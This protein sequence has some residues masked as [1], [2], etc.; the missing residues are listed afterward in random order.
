MRKSLLGFIL[1]SLCILSAP[2]VYSQE[3]EPD[4]EETEKKMDK[5]VKQAYEA[6]EAEEY[7]FAIE[8]LKD[9]FTEVRGRDEKTEI[10]FMLGESYRKIND[11]RSAQSYY[12]KAVKLGY[13]DPVAQ[14]YYADMLKAQGE[15]EEAITAYQEYR[16]ANPS[17]S[18]G[19]M[20]I[21]S[22]KKAVEWIEE[23]SR[24]QVDNMKDFN[25]RDMDFSVVIAGKRG[26]NELI[27]VSSRDES[28]GNKEDGWTGQSF[29]DLY[30]TSAERKSR[31]RRGRS[32][33]G[34]EDLKPME[35]KWS[36]PVPLDEEWINTK[37]HEGTATMDSRKKELYYT[38]CISDK[39]MKL[40][41]TIY[42]SE[43]QGQGWREPEQ[44]IIGNDT[45][46]N[47]G[48][49]S[50]SPDDQILYFVSDAFNSK[51]E[52]DIFMT[53]FDRRSKTWET[54]K[55]LGSKVNTTGRELFPF[56]HDDGYLYFASDGHPGMGGLDIFRIKL[57]ENG[58][59]AADGEVE[60][61]KYPIN[62]NWDDFHLVFMPGGDEV[63]YLSSNRKGSKSDDI[64]SVV[65]VPLVF[66]LEGVVTSSKSGRPVPQATVK[67]DG[68]DGTSIET[69]ADED[70]YYLFEEESINKD[71]QYTVTFEK[72]KFLTNTGNVT[73][74]GVP[75]SAFEFV[76]SESHFLNK[77]VLNKEIDPIEEPIV[78]PNVFFDLAKWDLRP[79]ARN[80]LDSVVTILENNPTIVIELRSHT[81]YRDSDEKN[82]KLSQKRAD[83]CVSYLISKGVVADRLVARGM[84]ESEPFT[85]PDNYKG[86]GAG[87]F[88]VGATLTES[89]IKALDPE[90][91][92][93]A[94][95]INRRTDFK[96]LRDDYVPAGGIAD[97]S[98]DPKDI[99]AEKKDEA[100]AP[101]EIYVLG[102]R[103][104]FGTISKK[105]GI[106]IV[107]LKKLNNGLRG[108][109]PFEGLQLKVDP[110]GN[111]EEWDATHYQIK[112]RG[113]SLKDVAKAV[114]MKAKDLEDLNPDLDESLLQPGY[115]VRTKK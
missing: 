101:G 4:S 23:P 17:D 95:Q 5:K 71:V 61:M 74:I 24:Y 56:V 42:K 66:R 9:A 1:L 51:G 44:V 100:N 103:E 13:K 78:L 22:T 62:T 41:C 28:T 15:F 12:E 8:L 45:S 59:P 29:M 80:A 69:T 112:R 108:V 75:L 96:V 83:T 21:E 76:P 54:P 46:A 48:H 20:G 2:P 55:N 99:L 72:P 102:N 67:L 36:T 6:Y 11:Y 97:E 30:F 19:E 47:V 16:Q 63:G 104:S 52:H 114:G 60:N 106:N 39:R 86:Y 64:Y 38:K 113:V 93:V 25:S 90:K 81:D 33:G 79:E 73:T 82:N 53:T 94:N 110:E 70:G 77:L 105:F 10:L 57:A 50:L 109:R 98:V 7:S 65:K 87:Q 91:F 35:M 40:G 68:S 43:K 37:D 3:K 92:E 18:R 26:E 14:L 88:E 34:E 27:F 111:Y 49:P 84:G 32:S 31:G 89:F 115:W 107:E 85:I 58:M